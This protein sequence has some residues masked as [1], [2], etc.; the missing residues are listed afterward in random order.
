MGRFV[1]GE[2]ERALQV[3][4]LCSAHHAKCPLVRGMECA[5]YDLVVPYYCDAPQPQPL[6]K[7]YYP[8]F[9]NK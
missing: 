9:I 4:V 5:Y 1:W 2:R 7:Q 3:L 6:H 8:P